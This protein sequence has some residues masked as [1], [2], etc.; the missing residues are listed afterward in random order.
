VYCVDNMAHGDLPPHVAVDL[1]QL[2]PTMTLARYDALEKLT[3]ALARDGLLDH[4]TL[5]G[6]TRDGGSVYWPNLCLFVYVIT[7]DENSDEVRTLDGQYI[8]IQVHAREIIVDVVYDS[9]RGLCNA[10][11]DIRHLR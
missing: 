9:L 8:L 7:A 4:R 5:V 3:L 2:R 11:T 10:V 6:S 1:A